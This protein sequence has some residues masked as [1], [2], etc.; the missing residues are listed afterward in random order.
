[1]GWLVGRQEC[2]QGGTQAIW[3]R[4]IEW[5]RVGI[6]T[7]KLQKNAVRKT[8]Q[9]YPRFLA[10]CFSVLLMMMWCLLKNSKNPKKGSSGEPLFRF[11]SDTSP[12][13]SIGCSPRKNTASQ[14]KNRNQNQKVSTVTTLPSPLHPIWHST[15]VYTEDVPTPDLSCPWYQPSNSSSLGTFH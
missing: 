13:S 1:M 9:L 7:K 12:H 6:W 3:W 15:P 2:L 4:M 10:T 5:W 11:H 8:T 14:K